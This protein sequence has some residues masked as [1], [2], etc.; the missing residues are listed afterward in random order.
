[1]AEWGKLIAEAHKRNDLVR[2]RALLPVGQVDVND[3]ITDK[4]YGKL[5]CF[6]HAVRAIVKHSKRHFCK[7]FVTSVFIKKRNETQMR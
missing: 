1:M 2:V 6:Y 5:H 3:M 4:N 7:N